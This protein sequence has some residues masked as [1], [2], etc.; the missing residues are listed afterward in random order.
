MR[1]LKRSKFRASQAAAGLLIDREEG[2][3]QPV[4]ILLIAVWFGLVAGL[5]EGLLEGLVELRV[6]GPTTYVW[7]QV[8]WVSALITGIL[9]T[10]GGIAV[11]IV[12]R[13]FPRFKLVW[14]SIFAFTFLTLS[15]WVPL[16]LPWPIHRYATWVLAL[17]LAV[18]FT[19]WF[20]KRQAAT[21]RFWRKSLPLV[22][23]TALLAFVGVQGGFWLQERVAVAS[24]PPAAPNAPSI[25]VLVVDTLRAD[26]MSSY[27]YHRPTSPNLDRLAREGVLFESAF[28]TAP[29]TAPSHASLL[30]GRYPHEHGVQ[31]IDQ[32]PKLGEQ[33]PTL[34]EALRNRGY[35]TAAFSANVF[36]FTRE[37]GFGQGFTHFEDYFQSFGDMLERAHHG[38]K[39]VS[40]VLRP[41]GYEDIPGR[42]R[43]ADINHSLLRWLER[44]PDKPF[45]AFV[46]YLDVHDPYFPPQP[47]RSKFSTLEN[48]GGLI[49]HLLGH[50]NPELAPS[51]VQNEIDAYDGAIS[52]VDDQIAQL[53]AAIEN[54]G[55]GNNLLVVFTSDH[56]EAF[57]EHGTFI[58]ANSVYREEIHVPLIF[59]KPGQIPVGVRVSEPVTNASL[60]ATI[61]SFLGEPGQTFF[62]APSLTPLWSA[63]GLHPNWPLPLA[64]MEH[65][66][67]MP[68]EAASSAGSMRSWVSP[69]HHYIEHEALGTE[70]YNWRQDPLESHNLAASEEGQAII[71]WFRSS[72]ETVLAPQ[73]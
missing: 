64:E 61:M 18:V 47:Y 8:I 25:L 43:A 63:S 71:G 56:G 16:A 31:W 52:Y 50:S 23:T 9:F 59:W 2:L 19:Q 53:M 30:T 38:R 51:E 1:F 32:Q 70:L 17:G 15:G 14:L 57:G 13:L 5:V 67:D 69:E 68:E 36:W 42:R 22:L 66:P 27:G 11:S 65:W 40:I 62:P 54:L 33:Y 45:F 55:M 48:P 20:Y 73:P 10:I 28:S 12:S 26:H 3:K 58:H 44:D 29:Y 35:R 34:A 24:L 46:N 39:F 72:V 21:L 6:H 4:R 41:L 7:L 49:N 37:Q 60:P